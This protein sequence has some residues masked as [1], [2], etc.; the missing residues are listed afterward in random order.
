M[1]PCLSTPITHQM[2]V[3]GKACTTSLRRLNGVY[4]KYTPQ[5]IITHVIL[6]CHAICV[7]IDA[8]PIS[9]IGKA[10]I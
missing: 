7:Y 10:C 5:P 3:F 2:P 8:G 4:D 1:I 6:G 9:D